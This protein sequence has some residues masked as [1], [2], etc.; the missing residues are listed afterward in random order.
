MGFD[1]AIR[2]TRN[3]DRPDLSRKLCLSAGK[4]NR[5]EAV[6]A[7][8]RQLNVKNSL[9]AYEESCGVEPQ[10]LCKNYVHKHVSFSLLNFQLLIISASSCER[11]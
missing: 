7:Q 9:A 8:C 6:R 4:M 10:T 2:H 1:K 5:W 11:A 3:T